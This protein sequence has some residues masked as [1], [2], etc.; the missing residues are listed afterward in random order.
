LNAEVVLAIPPPLDAT[1]FRSFELGGWEYAA[2]AYADHWLS[3]TS[4]TI[5]ALLDSAGVAPGLRVLDVATGP[6]IVAQAAVEVGARVVAQAAVVAGAR[7][8]GLDFSLTMAG[9][10]RAAYPDLRI[11]SGDAEA[12]PIRPESHGAVLMNFGML[13]L[14]QPERAVAEAFE[15][16][17]SGGRLAFTV[18]GAP[19]QAVVF[20]IV[21]EAIQEFGDASVSLPTG[22]PFFR[23]SDPDV[24][25]ELLTS[26]GFV[27]PQTRQLPLVWRIASAELLFDAMYYGTARTGGLLRKQ[28]PEALAGIRRAVVE[29]LGIYQGGDGLAVPMPA[30]LTWGRKP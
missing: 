19:E 18:W 5:P 27:D 14:S 3:L 7:V 6:G 1:T 8:V 15:A 2:G 26:A 22:P 13:H 25:H 23:F 30:V 21:L 16:L 28:S 9:L 20:S 17:Q 12:L 11:L 24:A 10:A 4:Q 29:Q